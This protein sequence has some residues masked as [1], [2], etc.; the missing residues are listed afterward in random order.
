LGDGYIG[1]QATTRARVVT[2]RL[3]AW[4]QV[5]DPRKTAEIA[6][7]A[8]QLTMHDDPADRFIVATA[9][10]AQAP[11]VTRDAA[12]RSTKLVPTIW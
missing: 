9:M 3:V 11:L 1:S 6:L 7:R 2:R 10:R 8:D 12:I 4:T 5:F